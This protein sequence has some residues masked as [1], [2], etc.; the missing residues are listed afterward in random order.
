MD[1]FLPK[2]AGF[3]PVKT[4]E[5]A[6]QLCTCQV[7]KDVAI[8]TGLHMFLFLAVSACACTRIFRIFH[9]SLPLSAYLLSQLLQLRSQLTSTSKV[10]LPLTL[11]FVPNLGLIQSASIIPTYLPTH[12]SLNTDQSNKR[13]IDY[14]TAPIAR[15]QHVFVFPRHHAPY[16]SLS[17]L[18]FKVSSTL[19]QLC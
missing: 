2:T 9:L 6:E 19:N 11:S 14:L 16:E 18:I 15:V 8:A 4:T 10:V 12:A 17:D 7:A 13:G 1:V 3:V 5:T